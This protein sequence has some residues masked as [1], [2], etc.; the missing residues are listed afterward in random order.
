[1]P[2]DSVALGT[3]TAVSTAKAVRTATCLKKA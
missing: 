2:N 3:P 1:M